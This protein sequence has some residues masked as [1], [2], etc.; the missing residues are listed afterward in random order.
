VTNL[1]PGGCQVTGSLPLRLGQTIRCVL[2]V[3]GCALDVGIDS[4]VVWITDTV[5]GLQFENL[6]SGMKLRLAM[7]LYGAKKAA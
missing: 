7:A 4:R 6:P 1:S 5:F 3:P 2:T